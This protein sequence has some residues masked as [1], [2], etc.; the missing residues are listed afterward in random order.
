MTSCRLPNTVKPIW[1]L[2]VNLVFGW[3]RHLAT[4]ANDP[5]VFTALDSYLQVC[6]IYSLDV[7]FLFSIVVNVKDVNTQG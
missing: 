5:Y 4:T 6:C 7:T 1:V 2:G 3:A